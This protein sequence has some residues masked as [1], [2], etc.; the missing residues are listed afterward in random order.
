[1]LIGL[2][3]LHRYL[4]FFRLYNVEA[5]GG[6][7]KGQVFPTSSR[8]ILSSLVITLHGECTGIPIKPKGHVR[9]VRCRAVPVPSPGDPSAALRGGRRI[10]LTSI[11]TS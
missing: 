7:P 10:N 2:G 5:G 1:M 4:E 9:E 8:R 11:Q 3:M 6:H